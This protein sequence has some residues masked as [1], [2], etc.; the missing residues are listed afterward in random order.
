M[1]KAIAGFKI[2]VTAVQNVFKLSQNKN[3]EYQ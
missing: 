3:K 1:L 2:E